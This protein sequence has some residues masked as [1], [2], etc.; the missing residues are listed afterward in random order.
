MMLIIRSIAGLVF[1]LALMSGALYF[2]GGGAAYWQAWTF[3][4][5]F[6]VCVLLI[7]L[8]LMVKD[9]ALLE[10]RVQAGPVAET[11]LSQQ[12]IQIIA[13]IAFLAV[14]IVSALD[15]RFGWTNPPDWAVPLGNALVA[16]GLLIVFFVFRENTFTSGTIEVAK[17]QHVISTGPYALIR[18][19]MYSGAL[20]MLAG[21][22]LALDSWAGLLAIIPL[23]LVIMVRAIDEERF[24]AAELPG[25]DAYRAKVRKRLMPLVW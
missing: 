11:R 1:L 13:A 20:I 14:F 2:A 4:T 10:R 22:P 23:K 15:H 25:Y 19:P 8:Y 12:I 21:V 9:R 7:T 17:D 5:V 6:G 24:L 16:I 18:H 3:L